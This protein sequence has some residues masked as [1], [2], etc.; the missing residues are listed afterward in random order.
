M[1]TEK[2]VIDTIWRSSPA[3]VRMEIIGDLRG[4]FFY[5]PRD[6]SVDEGEFDDD[7]Y[8]FKSEDEEGAGEADVMY[9]YWAGVNF[10]R[11][12]EYEARGGKAEE[13]V[14]KWIDRNYRAGTGLGR[15]RNPHRPNM[16]SGTVE[17]VTHHR[18]THGPL[19]P[20]GSL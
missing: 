3:A 15:R 2:E 8:G 6:R 14:W 17:R 5:Q 18:E 16:E 12:K 10:G 9:R 4:G 20:G 11:G 1:V 7:T 13:L 19:L